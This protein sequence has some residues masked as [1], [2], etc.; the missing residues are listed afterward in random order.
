MSNVRR[1][2]RQLNLIITKEILSEV[3]TLDNNI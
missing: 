1:Q 3:Q 2:H